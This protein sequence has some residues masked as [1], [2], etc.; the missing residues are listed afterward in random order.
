VKMNFSDVQK[1]LMNL[2]MEKKLPRED[3]YSVMLVLTKEEKAEKMILA[4]EKKEDWTPD[5]ICQIAGE[6]AYGKNPT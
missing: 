6:I 5:E 1:R 3:L 4:L 2:L